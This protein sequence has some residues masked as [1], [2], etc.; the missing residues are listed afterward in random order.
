MFYYAAA[1]DQPIGEWNVSS[2]ENM[3]HAHPAPIDAVA[4]RSNPASSDRDIFTSASS[5]NQDLS[6]WDPQ[7][8]GYTYAS[9]ASRTTGA[10][11]ALVLLATIWQLAATW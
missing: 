2:V 4:L 9:A 5:F 10:S 1:F 6:S 7:P 8:P 3:G 11:A